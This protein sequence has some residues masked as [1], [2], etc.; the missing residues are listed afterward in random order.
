MVLC[1]KITSL[2]TSPTL[3]LMTIKMVSLLLGGFKQDDLTGLALGLVGAKLPRPPFQLLH[4]NSRAPYPPVY[5]SKQKQL[6]SKERLKLLT[7]LYGGKGKG[8][9]QLGSLN[10][11]DKEVREGTRQSQDALGT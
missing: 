7:V 9:V 5:N 10:E 4:L 3:R 8:R 11:W 2:S 6:V 1:H